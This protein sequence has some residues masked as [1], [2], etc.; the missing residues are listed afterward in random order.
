MTTPVS[1]ISGLASGIQWQDMVTQLVSLQSRQQL[2]PLT[3]KQTADKSEES[4]W[5]T[6]QGL[7]SALQD[8]A[9]QIANQSALSGTTASAGTSASG[10][11]LFSA[12]TTATAAPGSY[13][14]EV[15]SL[16]AAEKLSGNVVASATT[17]LGL[18]GTFSVNGAGITVDA[19]DTLS[20]LRDK[21]N[22]ANSGATPS[23][24]TASILT[25]ADGSS[26]LT[27]ATSVTGADGI[28][29]EDGTSATGGVLTQLGF[30]DGTTSVNTIAD[31][32]VQSYG[33]SSTKAA[34]ASMLGVAVPPGTSITVDGN[35]IPIDLSVDTLAT[36]AAKISAA[37]SGASVTTATVNGAPTYHLDIAGSVGG[38][39]R[40]LELLGLSRAG[41]SAVQQSLTTNSV[42]TDSTTG[43]TATSSSLLTNLGTGGASANVAVGDTITV[44]GTRA[45]GTAAVAT[46]VV[47]SA[48]TVQDLQTAIA[49]AFSTGGRP[50]SVGF[51]GGQF[52][53][54]DTAGGSSQLALTLSSDNAGGGTLSFGGTTTTAVGRAREL[55][56]GSDATIKVDGTTLQRSSNTISDAI[57]G[58]TLN[59][60][61]AE[62][63]SPAE[64]TVARD[65]SGAVA[66]MQKFASAYN[67]AQA[68]LGQQQQSSGPLA[69]DSTLRSTLN[70]LRNAI[71]G[72][73]AGLSSTNAYTNAFLAGVSLDKTGVLQVDTTALTNALNTDPTDILQLFT[74]SAVTSAPTLAAP[75]WTDATQPGTYE[76]KVTQA[77]TTP[78][79]AGT[80]P[81]SGSYTAAG[82][83]DTFSVVDS[84]SGATASV[85]LATGDTVD[86]VISK[87]NAAFQSA[88]VSAVAA[89][90]VSGNLTITGTAYGSAATL[91]A[92]VGNPTAAAW[93]GVADQTS[94]A[95][96]DVAGSF[97]STDAQGNVTTYAATGSGQSLVGA[98]GTA[99]DGLLVSYTGPA[100]TAGQTLDAGSVSLSLGVAGMMQ[101]AAD[102]IARTGDGTIAIHNAS[103][104]QQISD[105]DTQVANVQERLSRYQTSL[106]Q[107][108]TAM[109]TAMAAIQAQSNWLAG[110]IGSLPSM[111]SG[112]SSS[113]SSSSTG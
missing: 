24:V 18:S 61:A 48:S 42:L 100:P 25:S 107:Q 39:Q 69:H 109:E 35:T 45:D 65:T 23:N 81:V 54:T 80:A 55:V 30:N 13:S 93:L 85:N 60:Q 84:T 21:I 47:S 74:T 26:R 108:F 11:S 36:I 31:G 49:G 9:D 15:D 22:A 105:L 96:T 102:A 73:V 59:L 16:A 46:L 10:R 98:T 3:D 112:S 94:A 56:A 57:S 75:A 41:R 34:I 77:A 83:G 90:D 19:T 43:S 79:F 14:V 58:V 97:A 27:L 103:L 92:G 110:Q 33:F 89:K 86:S 38:D 28:R 52:Q 67:A 62:I 7:V 99:V 32:S 82:S 101:R 12:T 20:S 95:G 91:T 87:L 37:G 104:E 71:I 50:V 63:G 6:Y 40:T 70:S 88:R 68:F 113:S 5:T 17:A 66:A 51:S 78:G 76:V 2:T 8:A 44:Q 53:L 1:Q 111:S 106:T 29:L 4:A 72:N 64:L